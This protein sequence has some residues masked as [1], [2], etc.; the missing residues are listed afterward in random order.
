M[1]YVHMAVL[2]NELFFP[3]TD[4]H[5]ASLLAAFAF[6]STYVLRPFGAM[7]FGYIG[8][9][10]GRKATVVLTTMMMSLSCI[11][12]ANLPTYAQIGIAA[13]WLIT[14][15]RIIQGLSSMGEI[16][17]AMIYITETVKRPL[18]FPTVSLIALSASVG[19]T[20]ALLVSSFVTKFGLDWRL[21]FWI[22]AGIAVV[23][24]IAR[25][26]LRETPEFLKYKERNLKE[27]ANPIEKKN[28]IK[29]L[30]AYFATECS[31]AFTFYLVFI[32]FNSPL[33][34][35]GYSSADIIL[36]NFFLSLIAIIYNVIIIFLS[37]RCHPLSI[38][39]TRSYYGVVL[40][41]VLPIFLDYYHSIFFISISQIL[42]LLYRGG[43]TPADSIY[44]EQFKVNKRMTLI[45]F[46]YALSRACMHIISAFGLVYLTELFGYFGISI[47]GIPISLAFIY[48][49]RHFN[50]LDAKNH[51]S[52]TLT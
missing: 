4:P 7:L 44:I 10:I 3:K 18:Q 27:D 43:A 20:F 11:I 52:S 14:F 21:A 30:S 17:G 36:H 38:L 23:G 28:I 15:C 48:S 46:N 25:T 9:N 26:Q 37:T 49:V 6:C 40:F 19:G 1:L 2:L 39:K 35:Q 34:E 47:I 22:G 41:L 33:K 13:S 29:N 16:M 32:Y 50:R 31:Y 42:L 51:P 12:M 5:T 45:T 8:D 24:S